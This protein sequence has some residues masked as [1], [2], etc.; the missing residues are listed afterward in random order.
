MYRTYEIENS[1]KDFVWN[2]QVSQIREKL[3]QVVSLR[4]A[5]LSVLGS[6]IS[7]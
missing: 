2:Y 6:N 1:K 5:N 7:I 4:T 3:S